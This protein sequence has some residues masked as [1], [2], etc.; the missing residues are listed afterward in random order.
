MFPIN[1]ILGLALHAVPAQAQKKQANER[2]DSI[3][4]FEVKIPEE[5]SIN[6]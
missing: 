2:D 1:I 4:P 6:E 3:R 5:V